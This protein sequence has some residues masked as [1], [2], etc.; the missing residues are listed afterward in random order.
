MSPE[1]VVYRTASQGELA[2]DVFAPEGDGGPAPALVFFF[3]GGWKSGTTT[4]FHPHCAHF[5]ARGAWCACAEYRVSERHGTTPWESVEDAV[6]ALRY[7][8]TH[9]GSLGVDPARIVAAGGS[10]GGHLAACT[11]F[12]DGGEERPA[13][14]VLFNPVIDLSPERYTQVGAG[15]RRL[16]I[17]PLHH[18]G[19]DLPPTCLFLGDRDHLIPAASAADYRERMTAVGV[20]CDLH[21]YGG[22]AHGFF[23]FEDGGNP[24]FRDCLLAADGFLTGLGILAPADEG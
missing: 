10:A 21:S 13:A 3:G 17:S 11:A 16:A 19:A 4:Q 14:L 20:R 2:L 23:N 15:E 22:Q 12:V 24:Y 5:A 18:V 8:R 1:R 6:T 9:A 7:V